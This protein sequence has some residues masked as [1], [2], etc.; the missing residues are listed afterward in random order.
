M[1]REQPPKFGSW[2]ATRPAFGKLTKPHAHR[3][4]AAAPTSRLRGHDLTGQAAGRHGRHRLDESGGAAP[5]PAQ[6][7]PS[8]ASNNVRG[9][10]QPD[11]VTDDSGSRCRVAQRLSWAYTAIDRFK[12]TM[13]GDGSWFGDARTGGVACHPKLPTA[14]GES[15]CVSSLAAAGHACGPGSPRSPQLNGKV[16]RSHQGLIDELFVNLRRWC[17]DPAPWL[18]TVSHDR[19]PG[20]RGDS[21]CMIST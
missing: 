17:T 21:R 2:P 7:R 19:P 18:L 14:S 9:H 1:L 13:P 10:R 12:L 8:V 4:G 20:P 3:S 16:E 5:H 11:C 6:D 15:L